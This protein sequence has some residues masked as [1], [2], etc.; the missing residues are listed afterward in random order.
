MKEHPYPPDFYTKHEVQS[1]TPVARKLGAVGHP[2][3]KVL[4]FCLFVLTFLQLTCSSI[5]SLS[6]ENKMKSNTSSEKPNKYSRI[7]L[8]FLETISKVLKPQGVSYNHIPK[9]VLHNI[10]KR[11]LMQEIEKNPLYGEN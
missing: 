3:M 7:I 5:F 9:I 2:R 8:R 11:T 10:R 6:P 1:S 4:T